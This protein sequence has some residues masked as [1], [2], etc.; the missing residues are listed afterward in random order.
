MKHYSSPTR[1]K[2]SL[3]IA[4]IFLIAFALFSPVAAQ[5]VINT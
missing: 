1:V 4:G 3:K 5:V 2:R